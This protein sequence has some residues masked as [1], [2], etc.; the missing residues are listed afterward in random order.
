[1]DFQTSPQILK[2]TEPYERFG[3]AIADL[4]DINLDYFKGMFQLHHKNSFSICYLYKYIYYVLRYTSIFPK[5][6]ENRMLKYRKRNSKRKP[7]TKKKCK[8]Y[9]P[10]LNEPSHER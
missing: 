6:F 7:K 3:S 9:R 4:G 10:G 2:G 8:W 5:S 1:M